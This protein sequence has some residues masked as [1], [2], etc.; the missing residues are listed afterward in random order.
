[1]IKQIDYTSGNSAS[2]NNANIIHKPNEITAADLLPPPPYSPDP[3]SSSQQRKSSDSHYGSTL[4]RVAAGD[5]EQQVGLLSQQAQPFLA[6]EQPQRV[7][8]APSKISS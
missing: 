8:V 7:A 2:Q 3:S 4:G 1:M 5:E 6:K